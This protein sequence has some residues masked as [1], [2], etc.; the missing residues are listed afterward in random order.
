MDRNNTSF[1][2]FSYERLK[3][4]KFT[5]TDVEAYHQFLVRQYILDNPDVRGLLAFHAM[6]SGKTLLGANTIKEFIK[7]RQIVVIAPKK[8]FPRFHDEFRKIDIDVQSVNFISLKASNLGTQIERLDNT[9]ELELG[10][11]PGDLLRKTP[12]DNTF[13]LI[14]EAH[15]LFNAIVNG[16]K[17]AVDLY[18]S[19]MTARNIKVLFLSGSPIS[20]TPFELVPCFNMLAG[21]KLFPENE[22]DFEKYFVTPDKLHIRSQDKF[23]NRIFGLVSYYGDWIQATQRAHRP[24]RLPTKVIKVPMSERQF[25]IYSGFR[26]KER[27]ESS[28]TFKKRYRAERFAPKSGSSSYRIRSRQASNFVPDVKAKDRGLSNP[29]CCPKFFKALEIMES[30]KGQPG[31][32]FSNFV[33]QSGLMDFA[34]FLQ[35]HGWTEWDEDLSVGKSSKRYTVISGETDVENVDLIQ[36]IA[37]SKDN[38]SGDIIRAVLVGPAGAEGIEFKHFRYV[39]EM[40]PFFN[41]V[42]GDQVENR[43]DRYMSHDDLPLKDRTVQTYYLLSDYPKNVDEKIRNR[44]LTTDEHLYV[45]SKRR[46]LLSLEFYRILIESSIDCPVHRDS[47]PKE[48]ARKINCLMCNPTNRPLWTESLDKDIKSVNPCRPPQVE[49]VKAKEIV[50]DRGNA[51]EKRFM[52][53]DTGDVKEFFEYRDDLGGYMAVPRNHPDYD[54]LMDA[55]SKK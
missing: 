12:L 28:G 17:N 46:K 2:L 19:I 20:N 6:G 40:D 35:L 33:N 31:M 37:S 34:E 29:E 36:R 51:G 50:I 10:A 22:E 4:K 32:V 41:A 25:A 11:T 15:N 26:D 43:I 8:V 54:L 1:P 39:I 21:H 30:H 9:V 27:E 14:D 3:S 49:S 52:Y 16:S 24:K 13:L 18:D 23:K 44:E 7:D 38:I 45:Q 5:P 48:R 55:V 47:L 53:T 42:R